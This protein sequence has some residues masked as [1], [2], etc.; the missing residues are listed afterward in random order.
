[1]HFERLL[2]SF[3]FSMSGVQCQRGQTMAEY[4]ILI[5]WVALVVIVGATKLGSSLSKTFSSTAGRI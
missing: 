1:M 5:A 3:A 4:G 2:I